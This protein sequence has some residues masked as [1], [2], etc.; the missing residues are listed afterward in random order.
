M[1]GEPFNFISSCYLSCV[2]SVGPLELVNR[3]TLQL[4]A[5]SK[6]EMPRQP[7]NLLTFQP[8]TRASNFQYP[9]HLG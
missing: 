2:L 6:V 3:L 1:Q 8:L 9:N 5:N 7:V 4:I